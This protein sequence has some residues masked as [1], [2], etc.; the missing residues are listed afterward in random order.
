MYMSSGQG[1]RGAVAIEKKAL[2]ADWLGHNGQAGVKKDART[3][4]K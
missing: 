3:L 1:A 4:M 2:C